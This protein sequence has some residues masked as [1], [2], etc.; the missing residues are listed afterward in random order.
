MT[1]PQ[2]LR[3]LIV[4]LVL[5]M[6]SGCYRYVPTEVALVPPGQDVRLL[7]T[8][9]GASQLAEVSSNGGQ[10][11]SINGKMQGVEGD[12]ILISVPVGERREGFM[13]VNMT[14]TIR[15]PMGEVLDVD[16]R[17]LDKVGTGFLVGAVAAAGTGIILGIIEA[18]GG[19]N[20]ID[21]PG[22]IEEFAFV[23]GRF[24]FSFGR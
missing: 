1:K 12:A 7:V 2:V 20:P 23:L 6:T 5:G 17:E 16:R 24:S 19:A 3:H 10:S 13:T 11:G 14:Q 4:A 15:V 8:R 22:P 9:F 18:F 21:E